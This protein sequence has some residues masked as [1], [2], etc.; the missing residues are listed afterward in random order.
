MKNDKNPTINLTENAINKIKFFIQK[1]KLKKNLKLRIYIIGGGCNGFQYGFI[2][3][4]QISKDDY[5]I[6]HNGV[7]L[8]VD[9][10]SLQYLLGGIIDYYEELKGAKFIV[11]NPNAKIT[12]SCGAS[13]SI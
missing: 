5:V 8:I 6:E 2:L 1:E 9:P 12:C 4:N 13:F 11:I 3:D 10:M 7:G